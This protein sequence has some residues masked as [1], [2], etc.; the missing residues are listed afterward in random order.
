MGI[1]DLAY[2]ASADGARFVYK[3]TAAAVLRRNWKQAGVEQRDDKEAFRADIAQAWFNQAA[4]QEPF[5]ICHTNCQR[6]LSNLV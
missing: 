2:N 3:R 4:R 6:N 1:L 5:F